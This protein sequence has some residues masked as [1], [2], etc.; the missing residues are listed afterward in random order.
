MLS[1]PLVFELLKAFP[2]LILG[3]VEAQMRERLGPET[4]PYMQYKFTHTLIITR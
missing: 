3:L 2:S 1:Q 4:T